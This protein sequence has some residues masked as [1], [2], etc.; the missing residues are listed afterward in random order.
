LDSRRQLRLA[1]RLR[2]LLDEGLSLDAAAR[3]MGLQDALDTARARIA[4]L[5]AKLELGP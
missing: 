4:E 5:Q 3:I 1:G 2:V